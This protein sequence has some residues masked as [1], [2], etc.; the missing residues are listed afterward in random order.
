MTAHFR[1]AVFA[2]LSL[3]LTACLITPLGG[4]FTHPP[5]EAATSLSPAA[6]ALV[7][8]ALQDIPPGA[9]RDH[10]T[11]LLTLKTAVT[12]GYVHPHML[13]WA[14]PVHRFKTA[15]IRSG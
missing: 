11:H 2:S 12:G 15:P 7:A 13:S 14:H 6:Q 9:A 4:A 1:A 3:S 10:H 8:Q 5:E